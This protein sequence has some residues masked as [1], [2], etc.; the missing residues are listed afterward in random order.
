MTRDGAALEEDGRAEPVR[1]LGRA[2]DL[3]GR[4]AIVTGAG[5][6]IGQGVARVLAAAGAVVVCADVDAGA[7][8]ATSEEIAAAG[9]SA[10]PAAVDVSRRDQ[11]HDLVRATASEHGRVDVMCNNAGII[12]DVPVLDLSEEQL[13][14]VLAVNL[15]GV[16]FGCQA[17]GAVMRSQRAGSIINMASGAFDTAPARLVAYS[18]SKAGVVQI[19]RTLAKELGPDGVRVNA[20]APGLVETD[21]TR[22]H[23]T[24]EDGTVD[25]DKRERFLGRSRDLAPLRRIGTTEDVGHAA[26]YLASEAARFVTGQV[27]R[28]NG[29]V[30]MP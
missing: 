27:L 9:G 26:L 23:Y 1:A 25:E 10:A 14:R 12:I 6:G 7:A 4:V 2:F 22:R 20:I 18:I 3:T 16:L 19:T 17:A 21:I 30:S 5:H 15:K 24:A 11:V 13:D 29:G 8:G 28:P